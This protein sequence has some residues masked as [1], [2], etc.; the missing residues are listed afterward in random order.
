MAR[1]DL[2]HSL[3]SLCSCLRHRSCTFSPLSLSLKVLVFPIK[4]KPFCSL[5]SWFEVSRVVKWHVMLLSCGRLRKLYFIWMCWHLCEL[6]CGWTGSVGKDSNESAWVWLDYSEGLSSYELCRQWRLSSSLCFNLPFGLWFLTNLFIYVCVCSSRC[7]VWISP[8]S[9]SRP[10]QGERV[11]IS[12]GL[13]FV[14]FLKAAF[15]KSI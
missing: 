1:R 4:I 15:L 8:S 13:L 7:S 11:S 10:S 12:F 6:D 2:F 9:I 14:W 3:W 5:G